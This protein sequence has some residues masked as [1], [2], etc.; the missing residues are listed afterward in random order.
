MRRRKKSW[1]PRV[2]IF[3]TLNPSINSQLIFGEGTPVESSTSRQFTNTETVISTECPRLCNCYETTL[4]CIQAE[5]KRIPPT[6]PT[7]TQHAEFAQNSI[8]SIQNTDF[9]SIKNVVSLDISENIIETWQPLTLKLSHALV[10]I[11][12]NDNKL[13]EFPAEWHARNIQNIDLSKNQLKEIPDYS[14]L[15]K[16]Q[17]LKIGYNPFTNIPQNNKNPF[18]RNLETLEIRCIQGKKLDKFPR[19]NKLSVLDI[20]CP[21][22]D[23]GISAKLE[24]V[25]NSALVNLFN[26]RDLNLAGNRIL[27]IPTN[28][29]PNLLKLDLSNNR[30][31]KINAVCGSSDALF[32]MDVM[33]DS[34][35]GEEDAGVV[36]PTEV[37]TS[38]MT[39]TINI[40][41]QFSSIA[42]SIYHLDLSQ[43]EINRICVDDFYG[44]K[45]LHFL[46]LSKSQI[47]EFNENS[48]LFTN[49]LE[50]LDI[51]HNRLTEMRISEI[52]SL[53]K[54]DASYNQIYYVYD[55]GRATF[56]SLESLDLGFNPF[57]CTC[58]N[59]K[60][61]EF[62]LE[63]KGGIRLEGLSGGQGRMAY[64]QF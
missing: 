30:I 51:S 2:L 33:Y 62:L 64:A 60:F 19:L 53:I 21:Y 59:K 26:L 27:H 4:N 14:S 57:R 28:F 7:I 32:N 16:V 9:R 58:E 38:N 47:T 18:P 39:E 13:I 41:H 46:N 61:F 5:L 40:K 52:V 50:V 55:I 56:P 49:S 48:F 10:N 24:I 1:C 54:L 20:S 44:M 25:G 31:A 45:H 63:P 29:P 35:G 12:L 6:L 37:L 3:A 34:V 15:D 43:N 36:I 42:A 17:N 22:N 11:S 23:Y 8:S